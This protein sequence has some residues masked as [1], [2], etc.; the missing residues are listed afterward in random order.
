MQ[1]EQS[2]HALVASEAWQIAG[3]GEMLF[4]KMEA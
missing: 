1:R 4:L 3:G 2:W